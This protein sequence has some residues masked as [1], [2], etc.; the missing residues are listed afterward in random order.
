VDTLAHLHGHDRR[1]S[2]ISKSGQTRRSRQKGAIE[3]T[4]GRI[5]RFLPGERNLAELAEDDLTSIMGMLNTAPR[6]CPG[7]RTPNEAFQQQL[8]ILTRAT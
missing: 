2:P 1:R 7:Y 8:A 4:N 5:R 6:R 3:N